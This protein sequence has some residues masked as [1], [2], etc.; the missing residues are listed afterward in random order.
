MSREPQATS[1][2][3]AVIECRVHK[4]KMVPAD[5]QVPQNSPLGTPGQKFSVLMCPEK[6]C[7]ML[8]DKFLFPDS[9][10]FFTR[11]DDGTRVPWP[12]HRD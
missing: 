9:G 6:S 5:Y 4:R 11:D 12:I 3:A 2:K 8:Y 10:G 7:G 1:Q